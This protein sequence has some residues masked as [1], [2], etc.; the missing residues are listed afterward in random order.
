MLPLLLFAGL[1]INILG[2]V[3]VLSEYLELGVKFL[4]IFLTSFESENSIELSNF[5]LSSV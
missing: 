3:Y 5:I 4:M 1:F 2:Y